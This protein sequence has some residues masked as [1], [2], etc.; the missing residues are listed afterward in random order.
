[1]GG[2][3]SQHLRIRLRHWP[4][5]HAPLAAGHMCQAQQRNDAK[6]DM[7]SKEA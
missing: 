5:S 4:S 2:D 3:T 1:M 7:F 6:A